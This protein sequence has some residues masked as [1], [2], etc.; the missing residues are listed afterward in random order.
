MFFFVAVGIRWVVAVCKA[1]KLACG[2]G[3]DI[4]T[5]VLYSFI[6]LLCIVAVKCTLYN[7]LTDV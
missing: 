1:D 5:S 6:T 2:R 4:H 3:S 7:D